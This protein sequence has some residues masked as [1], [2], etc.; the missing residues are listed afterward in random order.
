VAEL[1]KLLTTNIDIYNILGHPRKLFT[2]PFLFFLLQ[3]RSQKLV[4]LQS[5]VLQQLRCSMD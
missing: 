4:N 5:A 3:G 1:R 2:D